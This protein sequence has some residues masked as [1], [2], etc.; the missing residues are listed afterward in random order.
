MDVVWLETEKSQPWAHNQPVM[1]FEILH[2][3]I[4]CQPILWNL[5][6]LTT[7]K[8]YKVKEP[9]PPKITK[10]AWFSKM[11][12]AW[13]IFQSRLASVLS[14]FERVWQFEQPD[15]AQT[16]KNFRGCSEH[17]NRLKMGPKTPTGVKILVFQN[18]GHQ[19]PFLPRYTSGKRE[20][21]LTG[22]PG[23]D[24][25]MTCVCVCVCQ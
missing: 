2:F 4:H 10:S 16:P 22:K 8:D 6:I 1:K 3:C 24:A 19:F 14:R 15:G 11:A 13:R 17:E 18:F 23:L 21:Y 7:L 12:S 9:R 25:S 5:A 20:V